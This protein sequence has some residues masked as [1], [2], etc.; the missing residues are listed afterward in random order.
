MLNWT[1]VDDLRNN[2]EVQ[3]K[4]QEINIPTTY[5]LDWTLVIRIKDL[6]V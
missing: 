3:T 5:E 1:H 4:V 2:R 6:V